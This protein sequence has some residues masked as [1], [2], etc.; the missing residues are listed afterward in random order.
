MA[1]TEG[2]LSNSGERA[3]SERNL[4]LS[5]GKGY[6]GITG[7]SKNCPQSLMLPSDK[8]FSCSFCMSTSRASCIC[9]EKT[10]GSQPT[11]PDPET[12]Y[13]LYWL[14][15]EPYVV[16]DTADPHRLSITSVNTIPEGS[17]TLSSTTS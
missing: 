10:L 13:M 3:S 11:K 5:F 8:S 15:D 16:S 12:G 17:E 6:R 14:D 1:S 4:V 7:N 2:T 9:Q